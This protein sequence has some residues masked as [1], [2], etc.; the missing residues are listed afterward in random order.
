M[1]FCQPYT[2]VNWSFISTLPYNLMIHIHVQ[3]KFSFT[4]NGKLKYQAV[5]LF[6]HIQ[7]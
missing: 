1:E 2:G 7:Q 4:Y 5:H 6:N 3:E